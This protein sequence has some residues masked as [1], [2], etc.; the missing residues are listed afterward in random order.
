MTWLWNVVSRENGLREKLSERQGRKYRALFH[1]L[2]KKSKPIE[3]QGL[4][5]TLIKSVTPLIC[6]M[7]CTP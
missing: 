3:D 5:A 4:P 1:V 2:T 6:H 7:H